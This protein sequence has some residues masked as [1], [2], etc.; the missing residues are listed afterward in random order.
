MSINDAIVNAHVTNGYFN[1]KKDAEDLEKDN[2]KLPVPNQKPPV[3]EKE[4]SQLP[5]PSILSSNERGKLII[6]IIAEY[7]K[8]PFKV[9]SYGLYQ[10][11]SV[12]GKFQSNTQVFEFILNEQGIKYKLVP[13]E[14]VDSYIL[15]YYQSNLQD[16]KSFD[17]INDDNDR[18]NNEYTNVSNK[19]LTNNEFVDSNQRFKNTDN[20][21]SI[22]TVGNVLNSSNL[23][24]DAIGIHRYLLNRFV[25]PFKYIIQ[26][27]S[28]SRSKILIASLH[29]KIH[30][31]TDYYFYK[32]RLYSSYSDIFVSEQK[33]ISL[34]NAIAKFNSPLKNNLN[35]KGNQ[36]YLNVK[37]NCSSGCQCNSCITTNS[38]DE[39]SDRESELLSYYSLNKGDKLSQY[40]KEEIERQFEEYL[41]DRVL[42]KYGL[43]RYGLH[44]ESNEFPSLII[45][46]K[47]AT[48][49]AE[50]KQCG[51]GLLCGASCIDP[52]KDCDLD[53]PSPTAL[54][55]T[56]TLLTSLK[57]SLDQNPA[58][59]AVKEIGTDDVKSKITE[60]VSNVLLSSIP[61]I[62]VVKD[63]ISSVTQDLASGAIDKLTE[64][65]GGITTDALDPE[66]AQ[67]VKS[68]KEVLGNLLGVFKEAGISSL[69]QFRNMSKE[70]WAGY[71]TQK[72]VEV[73]LNVLVSSL[74]A[75]PILGYAAGKAS[76]KIAEKAGEFVTS[77]LQKGKS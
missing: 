39:L 4:G 13:E 5:D 46:D 11:N 35:V 59:K 25:I 1:N 64:K 77:T 7:F 40:L 75:N 28:P 68:T 76:T 3:N 54:E 63:L 74:T 8:N 6:E 50:V 2:S 22:K 9:L 58:S 37:S 24:L 51:K 47:S 44:E 65:I 23:N 17:A 19:Y 38:E 66:S 55:K 30:S 49:T 33:G 67:A 57:A 34:G 60:T 32:N 14:V 10:G 45:N 16:F 73:A 48:A 72:G 53:N 26:R 52:D 62:P 71:A 41:L 61:D 42:D 18:I 29:N 27:S 69:D 56:K 36:A 31:I 12:K 15:G 20:T 43:S 21:S 70:E